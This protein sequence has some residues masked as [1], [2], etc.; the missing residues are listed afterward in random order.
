M[1]A[2]QTPPVPRHRPVAR[3]TTGVPVA[4]DRVRVRGFTLIELLIVVA[5]IGIL[6]AIAYPSYATYVQQTRRSDAH[7]SLLEARQAMERCRSTSYSY[8]GCDLPRDGASVEEHYT[9]ALSDDSD[10]GT[11]TIVATAD[12]DGPQFGDTECRTLTI[13]HLDVTAGADADGAAND[14]CW[15]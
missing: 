13:D 15:N 6:A 8:A 5:V 3:G 10:A 2:S 7:L 14:A 9:L 12:A 1:R 4:R 11:F